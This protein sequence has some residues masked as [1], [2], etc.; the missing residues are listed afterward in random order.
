VTLSWLDAMVIDVPIDFVLVGL[1]LSL[2][3]AVKANLP[4][5]VGVPEITPLLPD[6]ANPGGSPPEVID[7]V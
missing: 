5:A 4:L 6:S 1:L 3:A 7:H 2:T